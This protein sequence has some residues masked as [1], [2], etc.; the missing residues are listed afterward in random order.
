M[1]NFVEY[2]GWI[3][4]TSIL[5]GMGVWVLQIGAWWRGRLRFALAA[6]GLAAL[7]LMMAKWNSANISRFAVDPAEAVRAMMAAPTEET[8]GGRTRFAEEGAA[9]ISALTASGGGSVYEQ[10]AQAEP[11]YR[12]RGKQTRATGAVAPIPGVEAPQ[13]VSDV[14]EPT[15]YL[16]EKEIQRA[17]RWDRLNLFAARVAWWSSLGL[18]G[19]LYVRLFNSKR[20]ARFPLPISGEWV[21]AFFPPIRAAY[22]PDHEGHD[23]E[24]YLDHLAR[25][26]E[27]FIAFAERPKNLPDLFRLRVGKLGL[28]KLAID[29]NPPVGTPKEVEFLFDAAWFNRMAFF[30]PHPK[31]HPPML[32][33]LNYLLESR[34]QTQAIARQ[35]LTVLFPAEV[36]TLPATSELMGLA[37]QANI[38]LV[39]WGAAKPDLS[40][41]TLHFSDVRK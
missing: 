20:L 18:L 15:R 11:A 3:G 1:T 41:V 2:F 14:P 29:E 10:A 4:I 5:L 21:D 17:D 22:L 23:L 31:T 34:I 12:Q 35:T 24:K 13:A 25:R 19:L 30:L 7:A 36:A 8:P 27:T 32:E 40:L 16:P 38:R 6:C 37:P 9:D 33:Y 39:F 26:G 28:G